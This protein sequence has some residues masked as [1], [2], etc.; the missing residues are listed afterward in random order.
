MAKARI[1]Q[2]ASNFSVMTDR[3]CESGS[4]VYA[5]GSDRFS[6]FASMC[7]VSQRQRQRRPA[8]PHYC[9]KARAATTAGQ[10]SSPG[11]IPGRLVAVNRNR[12]REGESY[13][14]HALMGKT[15]PESAETFLR[16]D[17]CLCVCVYIRYNSQAACI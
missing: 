16:R 17:E 12:A 8:S 13:N 11:L 9:Y 15:V 4:S 1:Y 6:R 5:T 7:M 3:L 10:S 2:R 14:G